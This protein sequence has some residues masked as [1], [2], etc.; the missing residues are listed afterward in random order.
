MFCFT[1]HH[2]WQS[3]CIL[4]TDKLT[5]FFNCYAATFTLKVFEIWHFLHTNKCCNSE[6]SEMIEETPA[7]LSYKY[8]FCRP[9]WC[10]I[11][12]IMCYKLDK[13]KSGYFNMF[14][15]MRKH[16]CKDYRQKHSSKELELL[17]MKYIKLLAF[18]SCSL[19]ITVLSEHQLAQLDTLIDLNQNWYVYQIWDWMILAY[20]WGLTV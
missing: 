5:A 14:S 18:R 1:S 7:K 16:H 12:F 3:K 11:Y 19:D 8:T 4:K 10:R 6:I 17:Y 9:T 2:F 13:S 20:G 15:I